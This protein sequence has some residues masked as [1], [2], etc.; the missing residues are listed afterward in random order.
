M[1]V[2]EKMVELIEKHAESENDV[3][4]IIFS[5][6][7]F[8]TL[9]FGLFGHVTLSGIRIVSDGPTQ[10]GEAQ[11]VDAKGIENIQLYEKR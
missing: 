6:L 3:D 1:S 5:R 2:K 11:V 4:W 7:D 9:V 10:E 8:I